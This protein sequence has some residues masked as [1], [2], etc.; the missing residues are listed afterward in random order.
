MFTAKKYI[1]KQ[2]KQDIDWL[3]VKG[4]IYDLN[5]NLITAKQVIEII[6]EIDRQI[7]A[8][9]QELTPYYLETVDIR[10][11]REAIK[12]ARKTRKTYFEYLIYTDEKNGLITSAKAKQA[13]QMLPDYLTKN[14][15]QENEK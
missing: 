6:E 7:A 14:K 1:D 4:C 11:T 5:E 3:I 8:Q 12:R 9:Q 2:R 15:S 13:K 10:A